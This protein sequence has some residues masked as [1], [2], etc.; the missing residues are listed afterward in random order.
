MDWIKE[1][2][3]RSDN[4]L[5]ASREAIAEKLRIQRLDTI[6]SI[7]LPAGH[8]TK[9]HRKGAIQNIPRLARFSSRGAVRRGASMIFAVHRGATHK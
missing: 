6:G 9:F 3:E 5:R 7:A 8:V 2:S 4:L 1:A